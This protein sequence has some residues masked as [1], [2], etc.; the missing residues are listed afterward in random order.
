MKLLCRE[1]STQL[2]WMILL[3]PTSDS[4][5]TTEFTLHDGVTCQEKLMLN[6]S[7]ST[8]FDHDLVWV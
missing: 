1:G 2:I 8:G 7:P 4:R 6:H 5:S 3:L